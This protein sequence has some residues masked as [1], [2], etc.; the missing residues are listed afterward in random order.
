MGY[1]R[2]RMNA[3]RR[4]VCIAL[5]LV[6]LT[7]ACG[8]AQASTSRTVDS[9]STKIAP[10]AFADALRKGDVRA[11]QATFAQNAK[12]YTPVLPDPFVGYGPV[13]RL[14]AVLLQTFQGVHIVQELRAPGHF[15]LAFDAHIGTQEIHIFDLITFDR[16]G[17]I[18]TFVS[19]G[20]PLA[21]VQALGRAVGPHIAEI[22]G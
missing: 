12:F 20:R 13:S 1:R 10:E 3:G 17:H 19:H 16:T 9:K 8:A 5:A 15:G 18:V 11:A 6:V 7:A 21:G 22:N 14:V 4:T 2:A